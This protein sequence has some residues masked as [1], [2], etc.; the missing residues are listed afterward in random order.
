MKIVGLLLL[1]FAAAVSSV[2]LLQQH[3]L[4]A[5]YN[6]ASKP[7]LC[8]LLQQNRHIVHGYYDDFILVES[9]QADQLQL[10]TLHPYFVDVG[11][12]SPV[13][14]EYFVLHKETTDQ[15]SEWSNK[16]LKHLLLYGELLFTSDWH[17][18]VRVARDNHEAFVNNLPRLLGILA[19]PE[20]GISCPS[21]RYESLFANLTTGVVATAPIP[22]IQELVNKVN[23]A[24]LRL[25]VLYLSGELSGSPLLTRHSQSQGAVDASSW[26]ATQFQSFGFPTSTQPYRSGYSPNVY[27]IIPGASDPSKVVILGGHYDSRATPSTPTLRAPGANDNASGTSVIIQVA[28]IIHDSGVRFAY[29]IHLVVFSGEE[30]GLY[31]SQAYAAK[32]VAE[33]VDVVAMLNG[34]MMAYRP[35]GQQYLCGFPTGSTTPSL[36][37]LAIEATNTYVPT[38]RTGRNNRCCSDHQS[39]YTQG[40]PATK[41][42]ETHGPIEDPQYHQTG[43]LVNRPGFNSEQ[44]TLVARAMMATLAVLAQPVV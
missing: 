4:V 39:F 30:Q 21:R 8:Q 42:D 35:A 12:Y 22:I 27:A 16:E 13:D 43:D 38:C 15:E 33:N 29:T 25:I 41:F 31:G 23:S 36:T 44:H 26:I 37:A 5:I 14:Y 19:L 17:M 34:D 32:M 10:L 11:V 9:S 7:S 2:A 20:H 24:D 40:Y 28:K 3:H 18:V 1:L 6:V